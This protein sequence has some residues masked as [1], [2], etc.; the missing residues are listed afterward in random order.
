MSLWGQWRSVGP[1]RDELLLSP[2]AHPVVG[3]F[4]SAVVED[5]IPSTSFAVPDVDAEAKRLEALGV[6]FTQPPTDLGTV[7]TWMKIVTIE[8]RRKE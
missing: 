8:Y 3:R 6:R 1:Q 7:T 4:V 5:G 2:D